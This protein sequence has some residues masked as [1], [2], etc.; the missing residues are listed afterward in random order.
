M[1]ILTGIVTDMNGNAVSGAMLSLNSYW[2]NTSMDG[3]FS[4]EIPPGQYILRCIKQG[5][6][7]YE[8][9]TTVQNDTSI[10]I[11]LMD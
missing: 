6:Q 5:Y 3:S 10:R 11:T 7:T 9:R 4:M 1:P 8:S 2:M